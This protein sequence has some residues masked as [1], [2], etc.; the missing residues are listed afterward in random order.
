MESATEPK[1]PVDVP[2][3]PVDEP[4]ET[5]PQP[6]ETTISLTIPEDTTE[7]DITTTIDAKI[8]AARSKISSNSCLFCTLSSESISTNLEHMSSVHSF[9]VPDAEYVVDLPGLLGYL[10]EKIAVGNVCIACPSREFRSIEAV[11]KHMV[12]KGHCRIGYDNESQR[13]EVSD[14]YD[15]SASYPDAE[16]RLKRREARAARRAERAA[17]KEAARQDAGWEDVDEMDVG[18]GGEVDEVVNESVSDAGSDSDSDSSSIDDTTLSYGDTPYEL[19]LPSG[20]RI[21]HR[22]MKRYYA[23]APSR[24]VIAPRPGSVDDE[25]SG[26]A[27][28]RRLIADKNS[29]LVPTKGGFGAFGAGTEVVKARNRGEAREA[30]RHIR[31]FRD[32][33]RREQFKTKIGFVHNSQKHFRDPLLQVRLLVSYHS[34]NVLIDT[35]S[36][37]LN[38]RTTERDAYDWH[39]Q[40]RDVITIELHHTNILYN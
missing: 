11:R 20:A 28:V 19:I 4:M 38:A 13:L 27:L 40:D 26:A 37:K 6:K 17:E 22:S 18:E 29:A 1:E 7:D 36:S 35:F 8:A 2:K 25:N 15:F 34:S 3:E 21:G 33:N 24:A 31:E 9:F 30:G 23:Q 10:G 12:D 16:E 32:Q 5:A 14:Y 39:R